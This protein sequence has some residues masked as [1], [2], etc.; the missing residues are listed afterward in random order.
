MWRNH[1]QDVQFLVVYVREAHAL[2]SYLPKGGDEDP[3]LEDPTTLAER[4]DVAKTCLTRLELEPMPMVV[5]TI[6][7]AACR[8]YDA[9]PDRLYLIA[10]DGR[11]A[12]QGGPGPDGF[13]PEELQ[14]AILEEL[15][16]KQTSVNL[17]VADVVE[18]LPMISDPDQYPALAGVQWLRAKEEW[19]N[20]RGYHQDISG[21]WKTTQELDPS[22]NGNFLCGDQWW[23]EKDANDYHSRLL[24]WWKIPSTHFVAYSTCDR[25]TTGSALQWMESTRRDLQR[26]FGM[27]PAVPPT[28]ILL[29]S[30][31]QYN[32]FANTRS[33]DGQVP[34]TSSGYSALH[35]AFPCERW[36]DAEANHEYPGAACAYWDNSSEAGKLWGP[37]AVR[38][39]AAQAF[40]EG[41]DP[42]P[43]TIKAVQKN[44]TGEF[45]ASAFWAE[46]KIPLWLRYGA[47]MYCERFFLEEK[48]DDPR[49]A[50][51]WSL[52]ELEDQGGL[53]PLNLLFR[54]SLDQKQVT[55]SRHLMFQAGALVAFLLDGNVP[56]LEQKLF[57][58]HRTLRTG[59][60]IRNAVEA[61]QAEI[62]LQEMALRRFVRP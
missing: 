36:L 14:S 58:F 27:E 49:W 57:T 50:R 28:V 48:A 45:S 34:P 40:V 2:D 47:A 22:V 24:R 60:G 5:D 26:L 41:L 56:A 23:S 29:R 51:R 54:F 33:D 31:I 8:A 16:L 6:D 59:T 55:R 20:A 13:F 32:D 43:L 42:S 30:L 39:A 38:H 4:Q 21:I 35:H 25:V 62:V 3:I 18:R 46:K 61:L 1:G 9:W 17:P 19:A 52:Q 7:D 44:P 11:V 15:G 37:F 12:Y 10:R 53:G